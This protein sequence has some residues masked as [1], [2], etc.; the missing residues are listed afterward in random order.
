MGSLLSGL[1]AAI[2]ECSHLTLNIYRE[3]QIKL[4]SMGACCVK[5]YSQDQAEFTR[6]QRQDP[7]ITL[8]KNNTDAI[9]KI[10]RIH[11]ALRVY[12][13]RKQLHSLRETRKPLQLPEIPDGAVDMSSTN[14]RVTELEAKLGQFRP[15]VEID[16]S[17]RR[18]TR[19]P[20]LLNTGAKY[21]G[22]W[23]VKVLITGRNIYSS[24]RDGYG[25]QLWADGSKYEGYWSNDMANGKGRLIH[26][27]GDVYEGDWKDDKADGKGLYR[28]Y[29][30]AM[31]FF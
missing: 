23:Y 29:D 24:K 31:Y 8:L 16:R 14:P 18:E 3:I 4:Y 25:I 6:A 5:Q 30:G 22:E 27:D 21:A 1:C 10:V 9:A 15:A 28:H 20:V 26:V 13:A 17:I 2:Y 11:T 19:G 12:R 7:S